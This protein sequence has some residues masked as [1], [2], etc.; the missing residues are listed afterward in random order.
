MH[1]GKSNQTTEISR[2]TRAL[3]PKLSAVQAATKQSLLSK[4]LTSLTE[5]NRATAK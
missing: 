4:E 3:E 5:H 1:K 2:A